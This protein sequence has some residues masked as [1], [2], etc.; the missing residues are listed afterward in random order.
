MQIDLE[1]GKCWK[2]GTGNFQD[3]LVSPLGD[4]GHVHADGDTGLFGGK[5]DPIS[6]A[7]NQSWKIQA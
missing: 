5:E 2:E 4:E 6:Q 7:I 3:S 1:E